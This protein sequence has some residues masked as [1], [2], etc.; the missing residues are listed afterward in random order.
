MFVS[1]KKIEIRYAETDQMGVVYHANYLVWM[2]IGRS[3]LVTDL[4]FNYAG[5]EERGY[6]SPVLDLSIQYKKAMR[7]GQVA[8]VR[9]WVDSHSKLKT[10]YG[11]EILHEDGS[12]AATAKSIHT[13]VKKENFRPYP[14]S[15]ID[16]IWDEKYLEI[17]VNK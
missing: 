1:E 15:K 5:L 4:G 8:T 7:Y 14:L 16:S 13:L 11:Y 17:A 2:E 12:I 10:T 6:I 3:Q 9:T